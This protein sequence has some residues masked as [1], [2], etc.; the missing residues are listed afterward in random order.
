M[1]QVHQAHTAMKLKALHTNEEPVCT[2]AISSMPSDSFNVV[3]DV[4]AQYR[5]TNKITCT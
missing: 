1:V 4:V 5:S 2:K 3:F